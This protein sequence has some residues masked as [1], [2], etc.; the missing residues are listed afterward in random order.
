MAGM[1][2]A[3]KRLWRIVIVMGA[4][5]LALTAICVHFK[6]L[7]TE[8]I[9]FLLVG[10]FVVGSRPERQRDFRLLSLRERALLILTIAAVGLAVIVISNL[11]Q[12]GAWFLDLGET[13]FIVLLLL[14]YCLYSK[15]VDSLWLRFVKR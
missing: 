8:G 10:L 9:T 1:G 11:G 3:E 2:S 7:H 13:V 5:C 15:A 4:L 14:I 6:I 12:P